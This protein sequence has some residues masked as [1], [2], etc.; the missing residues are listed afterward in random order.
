ML[1]YA[2]PLVVT[3]VRNIF[4]FFQMHDNV[5]KTQFDEE[6]IVKSFGILSPQCYLSS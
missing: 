2:W 1:Q 3:G 5:N 4:L 6:N